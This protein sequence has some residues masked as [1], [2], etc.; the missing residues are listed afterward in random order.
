ML[1][2]VNGVSKSFGTDIVLEG[3]SFRIE[4]KQKVALVGRNGTGKTTLLKILIGESEP[5]AGSVQIARGAK[6]GYLRQEHGRESDRTVREEAQAG[7]AD[8][9]ALKERLTELER[10]LEDGPTEDELEEYALVHEHFLEAEGYSLE[11]D[12][13]TVLK[14]MGFPE[15]DFDK[16]VSVL[17]GGERTRLALARLLLEEPDLLILDEPTNHLDLEATEWLE[18]WIVAYHGAVLLVSH[19]RVFLQN[20]AESVLDLRERTVKGFEG[21]FDK[22][23]KLKAEDDERRAAL[24]VK[25][26]AEIEKLDEYVRRFMNSQRTAQARG[27][28]KLMNRLIEGKVSGPERDKGMAAG[29]G[30]AARS[31]DLVLSCETLSVGFG[32]PLFPPLDWTVRWGERWGVIGENGAGK[33]TLLRTVLGENEALGGRSRLGANVVCGYFRQDVTDLDPDMTPL[34]YMV[35]EANMDTGPARDLL[36]RF[37]FSGE[38]VL[39]QVKTLSGGEKNKLELARLT[40]LNPNLL[41]LDEPT[42]HLD[43]DSREALAEV[44][45]EYGGTLV[46]ISH[47]RWLLSQVTDRILDVRKSGAVAYSGGYADYRSGRKPT[48]T[49]SAKTPATAAKTQDV[50]PGLSP[51]EVSKEIGRLEKLVAELED[52][53]S[54]A[55]KDLRAIEK[56]LAE[57]PPTADVFDLTRRYQSKTEHVASSMA[58]WEEQVKAL[59]AMKVLQGPTGVTFRDAK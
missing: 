37:L 50:T 11:H 16:P 1:L 36:G 2:G 23:L 51:R 13:T 52:E 48:E 18:K 29:F 53:V 40:Q 33:S 44:L 42:N 56:E 3:V 12:A 14:R 35:Y 58:A 10:R 57:L 41:V 47:D 39:R 9:L 27:R 31:G 7:Q 6:I 4:R 55:E 8:Q 25:Q 19:D 34:G 24:S 49:V 54:Q 32:A 26:Q 21:G 43:M 22:Y 38:D 45:K 17:S 5:D 20:T 30:K 59:E 46:L 28:Q 15:E